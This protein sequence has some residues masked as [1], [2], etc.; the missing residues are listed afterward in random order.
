MDDETRQH[1][2][3]NEIIQRDGEHVVDIL[4]DDNGNMA[5]DGA[6]AFQ[7]DYANRLRTITRKADGARIALYSY[8]AVGR[9]ISKVVT[10]SGA[11]D[12]TIGIYYDGWQVVEERDGADALKQQYVY[13]N[14][15]DEPLVLDRNLDA[16]DNATGPSDQRLFYHQ[17]TLYSVFAL[18]DATGSVVEGYQYDAYGQQ[19]V[20]APGASGSLEFGGENVTGL[21]GSTRVANPYL[22]N[23]RRLDGETG[24]Y[25]YRHRYMDPG[26]GRFILRDRIELGLT[27]YAHLYSYVGNNPAN[28][29]DPTGLDDELTMSKPTRLGEKMFEPSWSRRYHPYIVRTKPGVKLDVEAKAVSWYCTEAEIEMADFI[30]VP[31]AGVLAKTAS[32]ALKLVAG[33]NLGPGARCWQCVCTYKEIFKCGG[34]TW[35]RWYNRWGPVP[36]KYIE[37]FTAD[38]YYEAK[39]S[40]H[41]RVLSQCNGDDAKCEDVCKQAA[42]NY[43]G[44]VEVGV[45]AKKNRS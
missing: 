15:I 26:L 22:F 16:D 5:D 37:T 25:Y 39:A 4:S 31:G 3:F 1:S 10:N 44:N 30:M 32:A 24:L 11:Q 8:D 36:D 45:G 21:G 2:S 18:T 12:G 40:E 17:N 27:D 7:W 9:R 23:G 20:F 38:Y 41:N 34:G 14:Y 33:L 28:F 35:E 19:T 29:V 42:S 43:K 13:G 6:F